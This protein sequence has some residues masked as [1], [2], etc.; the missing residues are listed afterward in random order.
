MY[1]RKETG[2]ILTASPTSL[3]IFDFQIGFFHKLSYIFRYHIVKKIT[4]LINYQ[5]RICSLKN[6]YYKYRCFIRYSMHYILIAKYCFYRALSNFTNLPLC[7]L[8]YL[9]YI[10]RKLHTFCFCF[11][12]ISK[13]L[14]TY[15]LCL[16]KCTEIVVS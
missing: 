9:Q 15:V 4:I 13:T 16:S 8:E 3:G 7:I 6:I 1:F 11:L 10:N 14:Q 5:S 12:S 2:T